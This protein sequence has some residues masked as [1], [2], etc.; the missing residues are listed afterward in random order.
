MEIISDGCT[1]Q[2]FLWN[3]VPS[4]QLLVLNTAAPQQGSGLPMP[5]SVH[6]I[7][8]HSISDKI[9]GEQTEWP[10]S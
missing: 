8:R 7:E 5:K 9:N 2:E 10:L 4:K 6:R 3:A 1:K